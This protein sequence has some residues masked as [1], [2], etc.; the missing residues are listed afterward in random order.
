MDYNTAV[1]LALILD[2][3]S[4]CV[5]HHTYHIK[6][7]VIS[8]D[9]LKRILVLMK[10]DHKFLVLGRRDI[11]ETRLGRGEKKNGCIVSITREFHSQFK[12]IT[13]ARCVALLSSHSWSE[14]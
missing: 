3:S 13:F 5:E 8:K 14:R 4:F 2:I 7:Y 1:N 12:L 9:L 10:S 6:N 11:F